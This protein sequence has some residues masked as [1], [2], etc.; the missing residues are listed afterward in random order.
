[1]TVCERAAWRPLLSDDLGRL[2]GRAVGEI[3]ESLIAL[4]E[5]GALNGSLVDGDAGI[6]LF[7]SYRARAVPGSPAADAALRHLDRAIAAV[8]SSRMSPELY[9]GFAGV[10]WTVEHLRDEDLNEAVD[11]AIESAIP[12]RRSF[13]LISGLTGL[14]VYA[15]E[16]LPRPG[17]ARILEQVVRRLSELAE[18]A[19]DGITWRTEPEPPAEPYTNLGVAHGV[20]GTIGFLGRVCAAGICGRQARELLDGAVR[21]LLARRVTRD[22]GPDFPAWVSPTESYPAHRPAWCHGNPGIAVALLVAA[23]SVDEE[24]W[25]QD[26][27]E[28]AL[29]CAERGARGSGVSDASLCHGSAGNGHLFN[30]LFQATGDARFHDAAVV[31]FE[32]ALASR[33]PGAGLAGFATLAPD[34]SGRGVREGRPG[35]LTGISGIGLA[36]LA[37]T[38]EIEPE[39]DRAILASLPRRG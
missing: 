9:S 3:A 15:L 24:R 18:R 30:R 33:D 31:W 22:G 11:T 7:L 36:L 29:A 10:A 2:A 17:A 27:L 37:A 20:A 32:H 19:P 38:T 13:E 8:A 35:F 23:R 16:R 21:G 12:G 6:A 26:A 25:E 28:L 4:P 14:G 39:W 1:M 34:A 5:R